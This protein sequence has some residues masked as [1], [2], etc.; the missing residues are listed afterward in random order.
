MLQCSIPNAMYVSTNI[1]IGQG[2]PL[3][4]R[5]D[6]KL[7]ADSAFPAGQNIITPVHHLQQNPEDRRENNAAFSRERVKVEHSIGDL[8][9]YKIVAKDTRYRGCRRFLPYVANSVMAL[10]NRRRT[11][12]LNNRLSI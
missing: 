4:F 3:L 1:F 6:H 10:T 7:M 5:Q 2:A 9:V 8:R 11:I 12:I